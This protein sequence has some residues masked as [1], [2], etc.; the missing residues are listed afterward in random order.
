V[1]STQSGNRGQRPIRTRS[2]DL[3]DLRKNS[4]VSRVIIRAESIAKKYRI[5]HAPDSTSFTGVVKTLRAVFNETRTGSDSSVDFWALRDVSF[6]LREGESLGIVGSNGAGK[7]TLLKILSR[8]TGPT[9]GRIDIWGRSASLLEVGT[10]FVPV[11]T[12]RENVYLNG[13]LLGMKRSEIKARFDQIVDFA[14]IDQFIDIPVQRYSSGMAVRLAF[15]IAA[16]LRPAL[17]I[18]DE[19]LAVGDQQFQ[20]KCQSAM[21]RYVR[22]GGTVLLVSHVLETIRSFCQKGLWLKRGQVEMTGDAVSVTDRYSEWCRSP[23]THR[24][25]DAQT[26]LSTLDFEHGHRGVEL[27]LTPG[28]GRHHLRLS[29]IHNWGKG[30]AILVTGSSAIDEGRWHCVAATYLGD[31]NHQ[32][33]RI[34]VDGEQETRVDELLGYGLTGVLPTGQAMHL[35]CRSGTTGRLHGQVCLIHL[36]NRRLSGSEIRDYSLRALKSEDQLVK[37]AMS[38]YVHCG[39][40]PTPPPLFPLNPNQPFTAIVAFRMLPRNRMEEAPEAAGTALAT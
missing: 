1:S 12:G 5:G 37:R 19:V 6:E 30:D 38:T 39:D 21:R 10:G 15:A 8:I 32:S 24:V 11:L 20:D 26:L 18:I 35:G 29:L 13:A 7:S 16:H 28:T 2:P 17:F 23:E 4:P 27:S 34:Y 14:E 33:V 40:P 36:E 9:R 3:E 25:Q 22:E 31:R